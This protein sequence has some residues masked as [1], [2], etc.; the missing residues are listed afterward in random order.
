MFWAP[1]QKWNSGSHT[2]CMFHFGGMIMLFSLA[3]ISLPFTSTGHK[4]SN[5]STFL[6]TLVISWCLFYFQM[7]IWAF[8]YMVIN[9]SSN[10]HQIRKSAHAAHSSRDRDM[11]EVSNWIALLNVFNFENIW[12]IKKAECWRIDASELWC[13]RRLLDWKEIKPV[14]PKCNKHWIFIG[15]TDAEAEAPILSPPDVKNWLIGKDPDA[16]KDW[17]QEKGPQGMR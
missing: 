14:N 6:P 16:G 8:L 7:F 1:I 3:A 12:T 4:D 9:P 15:K 11:S 2:N 10:L 5:F 17:G 13:W